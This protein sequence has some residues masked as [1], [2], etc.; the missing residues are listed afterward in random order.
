MSK[1]TVIWVAFT[2]SL[3][4]LQ[5]YDYLA[6][7]DDV[8]YEI[9]GQGLFLMQDIHAHLFLNRDTSQFAIF[10]EGRFAYAFEEA[11]PK[12]VVDLDGGADDGVDFFLK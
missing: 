5:L 2:Q 9:R 4:S 6:V 7:G 11:W 12:Y 10:H 1:P 3:D 8:R